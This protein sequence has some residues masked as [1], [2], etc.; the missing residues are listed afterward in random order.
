MEEI[1]LN[2]YL[3]AC[4]VC[5]RRDADKLI[6]QGVVTVNGKAA[7][8]GLK[9]TEHDRVAVHGKPIEKQDK[10][11]ILAYYKPV[12][13][14]CTERDVHAKRIVS[15]ELKYPFRLTYAGRLD[16]DSEGLLLMTNDGALIDAMMRGS[17][18]HEKEY[19]VKSN[20]VWTDEAIENMRRGVYLEELKLVTRSCEIEKIGPKTLRI[21]L[22]QGLNRQIRRMCQTQGYEVKS[23]KRVRVVNVELGGLKPGNIGNSQGKR[24]RHSIEDVVCIQ[25]ETQKYNVKLLRNGGKISLWK[26]RWSV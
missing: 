11:V 14:I 8:P 26:Q 7:S 21:I 24:E 20:K 15:R 1:R 6:E 10:K 2:R 9:V 22:T 4:G 18:G 17:N 3:A 13:V 12:G 23:L 16:R 5:S 19:V 25:R